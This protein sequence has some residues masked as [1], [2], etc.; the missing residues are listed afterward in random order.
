MGTRLAASE[1]AASPPPSPPAAAGA[2]G[3]GFV[4]G[5]VVEHRR[6]H[7]GLPVLVQIAHHVGEPVGAVALQQVDRDDVRHDVHRVDLTRGEQ[8]SGEFVGR[9]GAVGVGDGAEPLVTHSGE[10]AIRLEP[11]D[12]RVELGFSLTATN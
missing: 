1:S 9:R 8:P 3:I 2:A 6:F 5:L 4:G 11:D 12:A 7:A 10:R